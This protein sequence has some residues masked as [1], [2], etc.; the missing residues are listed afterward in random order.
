MRTAPD[1]LTVASIDRMDEIT[2]MKHLHHRHPGALLAAIP[3]FASEYVEQCYRI[4]HDKVHELVVDL[5]HDH[6]EY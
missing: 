1:V 2:F 6:A 4:Y 5:P 3:G